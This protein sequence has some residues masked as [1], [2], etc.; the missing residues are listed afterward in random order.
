MSAPVVVAALL[1]ALGLGVADD[2]RGSRRRA[3]HAH[4]R[5]PAAAATS[6]L[7]P[8]PLRPVSPVP[9]GT[10][11]VIGGAEDRTGSRDVLREFVRLA[12]GDGRRIAVVATASSLGPEILD[13]YDVVF[14]DLGRR[15]RC[16]R[17]R[18]RAAA[19][20]TTRRSRPRW[21]T[22]TPSS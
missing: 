5:C 8:V 14:R 17:L 18:P 11:C 4:H 2:D 20:P 10:L 15:P 6:T 19:R 7:A 9:A 3:V 22:S 13:A 21:T 16:C 1:A 12:G